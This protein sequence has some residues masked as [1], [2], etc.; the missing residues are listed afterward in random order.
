MKINQA[1]NS[2]PAQVATPLRTVHFEHSQNG[3]GIVD[4]AVLTAVG[5]AAGYLQGQMGGWGFPLAAV[6]GT[7]VFGGVEAFRASMQSD[8]STSGISALAG[9]LVGGLAA[10]AGFAGAQVGS[11]M[12]VSPVISAA[13]TSALAVTA[14]KMAA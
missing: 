5:T 6:G 7:V 12:G 9:G 1:N 11:M 14:M 13:V 2:R 4:S 8:R 10:T 3:P